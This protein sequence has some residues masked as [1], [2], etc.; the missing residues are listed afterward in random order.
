MSIETVSEPATE[1]TGNVKVS[2]IIATYRSGDGLKRV[3]D[4]LDRQTL[5]QDE[6][7]VIF[8]DDG[9]P[10]DTVDRLQAIART[11]PNVKVF[12]IENSGWPSRPRNVGIEY[13]RGEY[14][15][16]MDHDDSLYPDGLRSAYEYGK[17]TRA[18]IVSPKEAKTNDS[19]W[20]MTPPLESNIPNV[21][22]ERGVEALMPLIP[23]K[24]YARHLFTDS[25]IRFPEGSRVLW[26]D[27]FINVAALRHAKVVSVLA[28]SPFYLWHASDANSSHTFDPARE[29]FWDRLADMMA[30][31]DTELAGAD[32][33]A[34]R[35]Y[36]MKVQM[37]VRVIDRTLRLMW[38]A[39]TSSEARRA[40]ARAKELA[41]TY[42]TPEVLATMTPK[43]A[44]Q[45]HLLLADRGDLMREFHGADLDLTADV[46][47]E[48][49]SWDDG[50]LRTSVT[51]R[52]TAVEGKRPGFVERDGRIV[53][54]VS[55]P[56][57]RIVPGPLLDY[58]EA[59]D[60]LSCQVVAR[61]RG[62]YLSWNLPMTPAWKGFEQAAD[63]GFDVVWT[64]HGHFDLRRAALGRVLDAD[65]F[66]F[67][68]RFDF[69]GMT[70]KGGL[71]CSDRALTALVDGRPAVAYRG[72][73][74]DLA[75]DLTQE[76]RTFATDARPRRG[77]AGPVAGFSA[78][79]DNVGVSG[80]GVLDDV[81]LVPLPVNAWSAP[82]DPA[83]AL[84]AQRAKGATFDVKVVAR[85]G[86]ANLEGSTNLGAGLYRLYAVRE[87]KLHKTQRSLVI[88][89]AGQV[90][91]V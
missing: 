81:R 52:M 76:K 75:L 69:A 34:D 63:S 32:H 4:S 88:D 19:W 49:F 15:V 8:V 91:I 82:A 21:H 42:A 53:R 47:A 5:P 56:I 7:E 20:Q 27:I 86:R 29:D 23:H 43:H 46:T 11:R 28:D 87:D 65:T 78:A 9:S 16:F 51:G 48:F 72:A 18:D 89:E 38:K 31:I 12:R 66:D 80:D 67:R 54:N 36:L 74:K 37:E 41:A 17:A 44:A 58:T 10:D 25:G 35:L 77:P 14:F 33:A 61:A 59:L 71:G 24:L 1:S 45:V 64:A 68:T 22:A 84:A 57:A 39:P 70:R 13:A 83:A 2:I 90:T 79:L 85:D 60:A 50:V 55:D 30:Y 40:F 73:S 62:S 3:V 6:F 26:E